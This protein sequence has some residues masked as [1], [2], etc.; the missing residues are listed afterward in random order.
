MSSISSKY[1]ALPLRERFMKNEA[2]FPSEEDSVD[3]LSGRRP[4]L[5]DTESIRGVLFIFIAFFLW[6]LVWW[7]EKEASSF[8]LDPF[9]IGFRFLALIVSARALLSCLKLCERISLQFSA[10]H[11]T[12]ELH[13]ETLIWRRSNSSIS[14]SRDEILD[15]LELNDWGSRKPKARYSDV[16]IVKYPHDGNAIIRLPPIFEDTPGLL[17]ERLMRWRGTRPKANIHFPPPSSLPSK[18]YDEAS[19]GIF[20]PGTTVIRH[21]WGWLRRGP[22]LAF[23]LGLIVLEGTLRFPAGVNLGILPFFGLLIC[24]TVPLVWLW[25]V[26]RS[27]APRKGLALVATPAEILMR[28][29]SGVLCVAWP[30]VCAVRVNAVRSWNLLEGAV[31][32]RRLILERENDSPIRYDEAYLGVPTS[33]AMRLLEL[34]RRGHVTITPK[35]QELEGEPHSTRAQAQ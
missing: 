12:L 18:T 24:F 22:Y 34:Y 19:Q 33:V 21:G 3:V 13:S 20:P 32:T 30:K 29:Q 9:S 31:Q 5:L 7:K 27:I 15:I 17:V 10:S 25:R 4:L 6:I 11:H 16:Y 26:R 35:A 1:E 28:T 8:S 23:L 2:L 14:I